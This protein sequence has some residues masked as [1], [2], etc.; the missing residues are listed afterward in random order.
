MKNIRNTR[1]LLAVFSALA[2]ASCGGDEEGQEEAYSPYITSVIDYRP[3]P[4]QFVNELP[5]YSEGDTQADMNAKALTAIGGNRQ[6]IVTLGGYGGYIVCGFD[7]T[8]VNVEGEYDFKV[9]GNNYYS[10]SNPNPNASELGG[11]SEPGIVM[12]AY[13]KNKNGKPDDDE[14]YEL[15]GSEY[16]KAT[17]IK[18]YEITYQ[19]PASGHVAVPST[20]HGEQWNVDTEYIPWSDNQGGCGYMYKNSYHS[21]EYYP[22]W[23]D[24]DNISFSGT[25]LPSNA[26]DESGNGTYWVLYA[27]PWGYADNRL[28]SEEESNFNIEW[29]VDEQGNKV[30]LPG[31]DFIKIYTAVNQYCGRLG[32]TSTEVLGV[33]DLH[34]NAKQ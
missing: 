8:I 21:Q 9:L 1:L 33:T 7:H 24:A 30:N 13:D 20:T 32:E 3:A 14:W 12:V 25:L 26:V 11:N 19:R 5:Q 28:N 2:V 22:K 31:V 6:G 16:S 17:T 23:I 27:Y 10:T 29:A 15:A 34:P 4:G 18:N